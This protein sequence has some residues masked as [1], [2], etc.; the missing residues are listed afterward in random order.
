MKAGIS[1]RIKLNKKRNKLYTL[2]SGV[3][4]PL[5]YEEQDVDGLY[6]YR[7]VYVTDPER[8]SKQQAIINRGARNSDV[9]E[10]D[11]VTTTTPQRG[12][13]TTTTEKKVTNVLYLTYKHNVTS[14]DSDGKY[15]GVRV[16]QWDSVKAGIS[17]RQSTASNQPYIG[18]I[19]GGK[20]GNS[21]LFFAHE[22]DTH[23][24]STSNI[25]LQNDFTIFISFSY[26]I[27]K[28][29]RLLGN[30][31]DANVFISFNENVNQNFHFGL[32][33]G[34]DYT[35]TIPESS[36]LKRETPYL[37]TLIRKGTDLKLRLNG[38]EIG[39]TTVA[40]N[41]LVINTIGRAKD[42]SFFFGGYMNAILFWD[43]ALD[44]RLEDIENNMIDEYTNILY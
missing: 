24:E 34:L 31:S 26:E 21:P 1:G 4:T 25:T 14:V 43:G 22:L 2:I 32:A 18:G 10:F 16:S 30:S 6:Y 5:V 23:L 9:T 38:T 11:V 39:T 17:F 41:D 7:D 40:T 8:L 3:Y 36:K 29:I 28:Y 27:S 19:G 13:V 12:T 20:V 15:A 35:I 42:T 33:S 37:L 44:T